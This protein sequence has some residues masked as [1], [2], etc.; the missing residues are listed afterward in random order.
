MAMYRYVDLAMHVVNK[1]LSGNT[2][3]LETRQNEGGV[4]LTLRAVS[5]PPAAWSDEEWLGK[6][7]PAAYPDGSFDYFDKHFEIASIGGRGKF[8]DIKKPSDIRNL[9]G[10]Q[11]SVAETVGGLLQQTLCKDGTLA[12]KSSDTATVYHWTQDKQRD[13][14]PENRD[15]ENMLSAAA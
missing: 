7:S 11:S 9:D 1:H 3:T 15:P 10:E 2:I 13:A 14:F 5:P 12:I 6:R 8:G 4:Q